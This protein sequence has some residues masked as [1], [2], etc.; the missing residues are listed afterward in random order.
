ML[1]HS[2]HKIPKRCLLTS[3]HFSNDLR[4]NVSIWFAPTYRWDPYGNFGVLKRWGNKT[5]QSTSNK[6]IWTSWFV[7]KMDLVT[8]W[9]RVKYFIA[10]CSTSCMPVLL[11]TT[12]FRISLWHYS[13][14]SYKMC[15]STSSHIWTFV[16]PWPPRR[17]RSP[18]EIAARGRYRPPIKSMTAHY[19]SQF[20]VSFYCCFLQ[21]AQKRLW[22][23]LNGTET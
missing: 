8:M 18:A 5:C 12:R 11:S 19:N 16:T 21:E 4:Q 13:V 14:R 9:N 7:K 23:C 1:N 20:C 22:T 3:I 2:S 6:E 15:Y 17:R 10:N